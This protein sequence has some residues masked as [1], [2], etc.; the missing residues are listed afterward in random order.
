MIL[1][2]AEVLDLKA[3]PDRL[4]SGTVIE[5]RLDK[6]RG[7][8]A[9]LL[10]MNGTLQ[11]GA[12][13]VAGT[14]AGR[15]RVMTNPKGEIIKKA[16]PA[17]A[18]EITGLT[19]VPE[20]GDEFYMVK[21]ER[22]AREISEK[23]KEKLREDI[24]A[25]SSAV[26]LEKLFSQISEGDIKELNLIVKADVQGSVGALEQSLEKLHNENVRVRIIHS[27]VG[28]INESD[29]VLAGTSNAVIIGFNVRPSTA[30][31]AMADQ[32]GVEIRT[33]RIIYEIID[34]IEAAMKGMLD[35]EFKEVILGKV[36]VRTTYKISNV[37]TIAG[38]Y[39]TEGKI[40][41]NAKIRVVRDGIVI[42]EGEIA[43]LKR[44]KDDVR[45]VAQGYECGIGIE[46]F[47]DIKDGDV[48]EAYEMQ[49]IKRD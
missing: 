40:T 31:Q 28:T 37:G 3:N 8:V 34:D 45:E 21:D 10:I 42:H 36:E 44:F 27:G 29:V 15:V 22:T 1:L 12:A 46:K 5:A 24:M 11:A 33:Y 38:A 20:A 16:G 26:S 23:R 49:E 4:A 6:T 48:F 2:Q 35:P 39:V 25:K 9:T 43:S 7:P 32:Q 13:I 18:V 14:A 19:D 41:R 30:V 47:N 17:R